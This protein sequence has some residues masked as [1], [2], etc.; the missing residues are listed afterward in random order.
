MQTTAVKN[1]LS[2]LLSEQESALLSDWVSQQIKSETAR[3]NLISEGD[4]RT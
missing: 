4:L 2:Q 3:P 1:R